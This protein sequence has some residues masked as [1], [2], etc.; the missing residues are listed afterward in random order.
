MIESF[1]I[2]V[3]STSFNIALSFPLSFFDLDILY[4]FEY[5][6]LRNVNISIFFRVFILAKFCV[7]QIW[8]QQKVF[9]QYYEILDYIYIDYHYYHLFSW[10]IKLLI[11]IYIY[12]CVNCLTSWNSI[13]WRVSFKSFLFAYIIF[14]LQLHLFGIQNGFFWLSNTIDII[15]FWLI[16]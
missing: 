12:Y 11:K 14:I 2:I 5:L 13:K 4:N 16:L 6:T 10:T 3:L 15:I 8:Y 1:A 9:S 7:I